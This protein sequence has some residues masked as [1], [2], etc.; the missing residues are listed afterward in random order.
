M[1]YAPHYIFL[2]F[3]CLFLAYNLGGDV[4]LSAKNT[5]EDDVVHL[6]DNI[7]QTFMR[8][9]EVMRVAAKKIHT[10]NDAELQQK[11]V[12]LDNL[13]EDF[14]TI[15]TSMDGSLAMRT[16]AASDEE[17]YE[18][19][20]A[21]E[22]GA[23]AERPTVTV[24]GSSPMPPKKPVFDDSHLLDNMDMSEVCQ[25]EAATLKI[26]ALEKF[27]DGVVAKYN[28]EHGQHAYVL[29]G[30]GHASDEE[31]GDY[32]ADD[33]AAEVTDEYG[34]DSLEDIIDPSDPKYDGY[35]EE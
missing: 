2:L 7:K 11:L 4:A 10:C 26:G 24:P 14:E 13:I 6:M 3:N 15:K 5:Q 21:V 27:L 31:Y 1:K 28:K 20:Y 8:Q 17:Y 29:F 12:A 32:F 35:E 18:E 22:E 9:H 25:S 19:E 16:S 23:R 33:L 30:S 34:S